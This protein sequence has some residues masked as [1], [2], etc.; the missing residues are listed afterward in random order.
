MTD[1]A[2]RADEAGRAALPDAAPPTAEPLVCRLHMFVA[3]DW[4]DAV[5]LQRAAALLSAAAAPLPR[6]R[7]TPTSISFRPPPLR[8]RSA[9]VPL[10]LPV[11]GAL[12]ATVE[13]VIF[14]FAAVSVALRC[15]LHA[16]PGDLPAL[17]AALIDAEPLIAVARR[18][19]RLH[20]AAIQPAIE[21][22]KF[23]ELT[24]EYF[25]FEFATTSGLPQPEELLARHPAWLAALVRLEAGPLSVEE[26]AE[27]VRV[28]MSY[29]PRDLFV[30]DW[31]A[32][33]LIDDDCDETLQTIEFAN[34]QLLEFRDLDNHLDEQLAESYRTIGP[35]ARGWLPFW[36]THT[37][38]L[39]GLGRLRLEA[40]DQFE[41]TGNVLK[42]VGDQYLARVY[43]NLSARFHLDAWQKSIQE[44]LDVLE[45][46]YQVVADQAA[47]YRAELME[48]IIIVLILFEIVMTLARH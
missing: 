40:N 19:A 18:T 22:P 1:A 12:S 5:D 9:P 41:R 28:R 20:F 36:R 30:C 8:V 27:A 3:F 42:L 4:G 17:A 14:D 48:L 29:S 44:S 13:T 10:E 37:R 25:V 39:R 26:A 32:A 24:E 7:R 16:R 34:L 2:A 38:Q 47:T 35:M 15:D 43:R 31:S 11:V 45:G 33:V 6:R 21:R 46:A 23:G